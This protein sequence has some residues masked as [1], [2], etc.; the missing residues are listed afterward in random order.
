MVLLTKKI[1]LSKNRER[2]LGQIVDLLESQTINL[3][4]AQE[5]LDLQITDKEIIPQQV[6][7][8]IFDSMGR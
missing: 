5:I 6:N 1:T 7:F 8:I 3:S 2:F 4:I